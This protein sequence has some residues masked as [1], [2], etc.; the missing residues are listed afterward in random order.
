MWII[1][2]G[3]NLIRRL[4]DLR[5]RE[6]ESL[7]AGRAALVNLLA[8]Y[9]RARGHHR[10]TVV[11]D[12]QGGPAVP[13]G[14]GRIAGI[15]VRFSRLG[16][17]ADRAI[18]RLAQEGRSGA[19]VISSDREVGRLAAAAGAAAASCEEFAAR[20]EAAAVADLKGGE[21]EEGDRRPAG[22]KGT[23]HRL[24]KAERR[25]AAALKRL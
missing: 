3:Y 4:P 7:E 23:A 18:T 2:D 14:G 15:D 22:K 5:E 8:A 9:R 1:V 20:L 17:T 25:R 24:P 21:E 12:G 11:F 16:E 13:F 19:L 6:S 10:I